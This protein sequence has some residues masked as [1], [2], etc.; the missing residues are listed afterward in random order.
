MK[1]EEVAGSRRMVL[2]LLL[3][4]LSHKKMVGQERT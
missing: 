4:S 3:H 2:V 1:R